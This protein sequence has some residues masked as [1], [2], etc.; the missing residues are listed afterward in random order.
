MFYPN[1][2]SGIDD[3]NKVS[4]VFYHLLKYAGR[5]QTGSWSLNWGKVEIPINS[6]TI[7]VKPVCCWLSSYLSDEYDKAEIGTILT[8]IL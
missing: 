6:L 8:I 2:E 5:R 3:T 1:V 4:V 7:A